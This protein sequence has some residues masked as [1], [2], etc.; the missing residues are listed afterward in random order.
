MNKINKTAYGLMI[1]NNLHAFAIPLLF[2]L[3]S[4]S[5]KTIRIDSMTNNKFI[6]FA[7]CHL[8]KPKNELIP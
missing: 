3:K 2:F 4:I 7:V 1:H 6:I 5:E 8:K